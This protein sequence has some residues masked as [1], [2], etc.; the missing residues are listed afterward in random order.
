VSKDSHLFQEKI[1]NGCRPNCA[2]Y[3]VSTFM[4]YKLILWHGYVVEYGLIIF[5]QVLELCLISLFL[6]MVSYS[7]NKLLCTKTSSQCCRSC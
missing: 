5:H 2:L 1:E 7:N 4:Y 6:S 3:N